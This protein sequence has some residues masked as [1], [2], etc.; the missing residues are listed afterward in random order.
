MTRRQADTLT[1]IKNYIASH[2]YPPTYVQIAKG[3]GV[4]SLSV[5][6]KHLHRLKAEGRITLVANTQQSIKIVAEPADTGRFEF[7]GPHHLWDK[8]LKC[9]WMKA[10]ELSK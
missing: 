3:I 9:Y 4:S 10:K 5:V 2:D 7:E 6:H 1:F 8:E